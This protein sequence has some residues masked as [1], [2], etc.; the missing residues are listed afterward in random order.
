MILTSLSVEPAELEA[1]TGWT[2]EARGACKGEACVPVP[3]RVWAEGRLDV[4]VLAELLGMPLVHEPGHGVWALGPES[5]VTGLALTT[6][7]AP[8]LELPDL[9]GQPFRL[10]SLRGQKVLLLAWAS[11]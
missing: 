2:V 10:S 7:A 9:D 5:A 11:Y 6:A 8:E 1:R 3:D 4:R